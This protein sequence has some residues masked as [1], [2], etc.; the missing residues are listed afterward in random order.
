MEL[1]D[2]STSQLIIGCMVTEMKRYYRELKSNSSEST[3]GIS[4]HENAKLSFPAIL[5]H[6]E[7]LQSVSRTTSP[8]AIYSTQRSIPS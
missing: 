3:E 6:K 8:E 2:P 4:R 5:V 7:L 1:Y